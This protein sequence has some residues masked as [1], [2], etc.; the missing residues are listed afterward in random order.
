MLEKTKNQ[1]KYWIKQLGDIRNIGLIVF[2]ILFLLVSWSVVQAIQTNYE[3]QKR[4][5][6]LEQEN[7]VKEL[8]NSNL[9][10]RNEYL[11][12]DQFLEL[13][14]RRQFG[15]SAP[16]ETLI[17]VSKEAALSKVIASA[18]NETAKN[19]TEPSKPKYQQNFEA[20]ADWFLHRMTSDN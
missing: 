14:A 20:W 10:L 16:G 9:K 15:K 1:S 7:K 8:E 12:T 6:K 11:N 5:S 4:I 18:S 3:L 19:L 2:A 13:S 17:T